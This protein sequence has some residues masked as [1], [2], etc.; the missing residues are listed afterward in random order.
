MSQQTETINRMPDS[1][2]TESNQ[3]DVSEF[4]KIDNPQILAE[5]SEE[6][7]AIENESTQATKSAIDDY[8]NE[9]SN[10]ALGVNSSLEASEK[11][12]DNKDALELLMSQDMNKIFED[13]MSANS[14]ILAMVRNGLS[15]ED[16][17]F[18]EDN[19]LGT[20]STFVQS[21]IDP[22]IMEAYENSAKKYSLYDGPLVLLKTFFLINLPLSSNLNALSNDSKRFAEKLF[23]PD[24]S[25][26]FDP[27]NKTYSFSPQNNPYIDYTPFYITNGDGI[28]IE[29]T[30]L[31]FSDFIKNFFNKSY[32]LF[33]EGTNKSISSP[34]K[35]N[36]RWLK[37]QRLD[38]IRVVI[39]QYNFVEEELSDIKEDFSKMDLNE[40]LTHF[41]KNIL[42]ETQWRNQTLRN[43][44]D[45]PLLWL[46]NMHHFEDYMT[47]MK[48]KLIE[49]IR[50]KPDMAIKLM[51]D[52]D[53]LVFKI[54]WMQCYDNQ[55]SIEKTSLCAEL[56]DISDWLLDRATLTTINSLKEGDPNLILTLIETWIE[57]T[58]G[59]DYTKNPPTEME[60][61]AIQRLYINTFRSE[62]DIRNLPSITTDNRYQ[63]VI[64][65]Q[66]K[67]IT[68][69]QNIPINPLFA[70]TTEQKTTIDNLVQNAYRKLAQM[71]LNDIRGINREDDDRL[72][73]TNKAVTNVISV[74]GQWW[75]LETYYKDLPA[76][77]K[78]T[79]TQAISH[80][81]DQ[82]LMLW[83]FDWFED[84][85]YA[86]NEVGNQAGGITTMETQL[87]NIKNRL[88][89]EY[90]SFTNIDLL[91]SKLLNIIGPTPSDK[92]ITALIKN[93]IDN[94]NVLWIDRSTLLEWL[95]TD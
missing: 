40:M 63:S 54:D 39:E 32:V 29:E 41:N 84:R 33:E 15:D 75:L 95:F 44:F 18:L 6:L 46:N 79:F 92:A 2:E 43:L 61:L 88:V 90:W 68:D 13:L 67:K 60:K 34:I 85:D 87:S 59:L 91:Y 64:S 73:K 20:W 70:L 53:A 51:S 17:Y 55:V 38:E 77:Q 1:P 62:L 26:V 94:A 5:S 86:N 10:L 7:Q 9:E 42:H 72:N 21:C 52:R 78:N 4:S 71:V 89:D 76:D 25:I 82:Q 74:F 31:T 45:L 56:Y 80:L 22:I 37:S 49:E 3:R 58:S 36:S 27:T 65:D 50:E 81:L 12:S 48:A 19:N 93:I 14:K 8:V 57:S 16:R 30:S 23:G 11:M 24:A 69:L 35:F 83:L 66:I 28:R 47:N